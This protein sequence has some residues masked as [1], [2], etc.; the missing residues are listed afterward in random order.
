[1]TTLKREVVSPIVSDHVTT[2]AMAFS[3]AATVLL[4]AIPFMSTSGLKKP[5]PLTVEQFVDE[6][7]TY[8]VQFVPDIERPVP[9]MLMFGTSTCQAALSISIPVNCR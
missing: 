3:V 1:M 4:V 8:S 6:A 2:V 7:L 5:S 9:N